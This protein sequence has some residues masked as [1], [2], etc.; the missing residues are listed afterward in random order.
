MITIID[1]GLGNVFALA[2]SYKRMNIPVKI[3]RVAADLEE[4]TKFILPGVG[5]FDDAMSR[6]KRSGMQELL[7]HKIL[8]ESVPVLGICIGMHMFAD[9]SEE[10]KLP[11][12]GWIKGTVKNMRSIQ[13]EFNQLL[14]HMGWNDI[15]PV[16]ANPLL[17][18]LETGARFYFLHSYYFDCDDKQNILAETHYGREFVCAVNYNN[19]YGVQFH[20]EKSHHFGAKLLKNFS[21]L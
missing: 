19:I 3:A 18:G 16:S 8:Q 11:G 7:A 15:N 6:V 21:D 12:F 5:S 9:F 4:A 1:Y 2:N 14:P 10:G 20:P 13:S 17:M